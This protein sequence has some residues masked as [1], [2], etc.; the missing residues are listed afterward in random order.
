MEETTTQYLAQ[1]IIELCRQTV[2]FT[3]DLHIQGQIKLTVDASTLSS[4]V[5]VVCLDQTLDNNTVSAG[6]KADKTNIPT[7]KRGLDLFDSIGDNTFKHILEASSNEY[8]VSNGADEDN[9]A[10]G[11]GCR[12]IDYKPDDVI[13]SQTGVVLSLDDFAT[14]APVLVKKEVFDESSQFNEASVN[15]SPQKKQ[16]KV[17]DVNAKIA[18]S[19]ARKRGPYKKKEK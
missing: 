2:T 11:D 16:K 7:A 6:T 1:A 19:K 10:G 4:A 8:P 18:N 5:H 14:S 3:Q 17:K 13:T 15:S 12:D 9:D